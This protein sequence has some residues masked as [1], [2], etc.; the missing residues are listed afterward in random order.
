MATI[1]VYLDDSAEEKRRKRRRLVE[2]LIVIALIPIAGKVMKNARAATITSEQRRIDA[3][4]TRDKI[5][6]AGERVTPALGGTPSIMVGPPSPPRLDVD[7]L[8]L[9]FGRRE[10]GSG[11]RAKIVTIRN[12]GGFPLELTL[13]PN[14][15]DFLISESCGRSLAA[16]ES[17]AAAVVFVPSREGRRGEQLRIAG[18]GEQKIVTLSGSGFAA[19]TQTVDPQ[20]P[21]P[22]PDTPRC[23]A[24]LQP[25]T[26]PAHI[27]FVGGG[28]R[29]I[30]IS[31]PHACPIRIEAIEMVNAENANKKVRGYRLEGDASCKKILQPKDR[32][33]FDVIA[34]SSFFYTLYARVNVRASVV[35][36]P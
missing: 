15:R 14:E 36:T 23:A 13:K 7:P 31:N 8:A 1:T 35:N 16:G 22:P 33:T 19:R 21:P 10:V 17:C 2:V 9:D 3:T 4:T 5:E 6:D 29:T 26:E 12:A 18:R 28:R 27:H 34:S 25:L 11:S 20:P 24:N 32:C 30:A